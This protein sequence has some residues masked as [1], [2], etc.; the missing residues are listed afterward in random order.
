MV[1]L[2]RPLRHIDDLCGVF[3]PQADVAI[4][5]Q[6]RVVVLL[7]AGDLLAIF[8]GLEE[9]GDLLG[10]E[11]AAENV[12]LW[13]AALVC[14]FFQPPHEDREEALV[15]FLFPVELFVEML[16]AERG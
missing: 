2:R 13:H 6:Y 3:G 12:G 14:D 1:E 15:R 10:V 16:L 7:E 8:V 5:V 11:V 4:E 9:G